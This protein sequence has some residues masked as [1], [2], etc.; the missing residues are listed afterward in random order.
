MTWIREELGGRPSQ[1]TTK[2]DREVSSSSHA[3]EKFGTEVAWLKAKSMP[4]SVLFFSVFAISSRV[5]VCK[6]VLRRRG[7]WSKPGDDSEEWTKA[8]LP[9]AFAVKCFQSLIVLNNVS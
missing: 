3:F 7:L 1:L 2:E 8:C 6:A 9:L 5:M 4:I